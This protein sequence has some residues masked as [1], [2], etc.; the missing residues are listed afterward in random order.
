M[1]FRVSF[2]TSGIHTTISPEMAFS[3]L[4]SNEISYFYS[5]D[6][7]CFYVP[8]IY[9]K[10]NTS[11]GYCICFCVPDHFPVDDLFDQY[12]QHCV[13]WSPGKKWT[14]WSIIINCGEDT[15]SSPFCAWTGFPA[16]LPELAFAVSFNMYDFP[17]SLFH[18]SYCR[19]L[20]WLVFPLALDC[21]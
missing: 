4:C 3:S 9:T 5:Y 12:H 1:Q 13:L 2:S 6:T 21:H 11:K 7:S 19:W 15:C 20:M 14:C 16:S 8:G 10:K 18:S 17:W